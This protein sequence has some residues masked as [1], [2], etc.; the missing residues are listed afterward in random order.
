MCV[1]C[2]EPL[3]CHPDCETLP[4]NKKKEEDILKWWMQKE[5]RE[6]LERQNKRESE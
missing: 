3:G 1:R 4:E 6:F 2:G 5:V